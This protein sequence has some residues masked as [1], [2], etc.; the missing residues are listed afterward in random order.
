MSNCYS[1]SF[2]LS[3][4]SPHF[5]LSTLALTPGWPLARSVHHTLRLVVGR[6]GLRDGRSVQEL[7]CVWTYI[8]ASIETH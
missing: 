7:P 3:I 6:L 1:T 8:L 2:V 4:G 5:H